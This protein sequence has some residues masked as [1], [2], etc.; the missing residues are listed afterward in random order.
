MGGYDIF[1]SFKKG[2]S[3]TT[4]ENLGYP[5]NTPDDDRFFSPFNNGLNAYY[6]MATGYKKKE[7]IYLGFGVPALDHSFTIAGTLRLSDS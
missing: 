3:W 2:N 7:I 1:R 4:P 5:I 6:S